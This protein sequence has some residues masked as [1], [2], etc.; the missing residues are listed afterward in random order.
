MSGRRCFHPIVYEA[1]IRT[2]TKIV[3]TKSGKW[4]AIV[5]MGLDES[6]K[7]IQKSVTGSDRRTVKMEVDRLEQVRDNGNAGLVFKH[8]IGAYIASKQ[9]TLSPSTIRGYKSIERVLE[10]SFP[11][12]FNA[13]LSDLD[14]DTLQIMVNDM[15]VDGKSPKRIRNVY[16]LV[17]AVLRYNN[18]LVTGVSL[19]EPGVDKSYQPTS[20]DIKKLIQLSV[21]TELN[22]PIRL[23]TH[24]LRQGEVC[25]L[26]Y[27]NDFR[28]GCIIV[29]KSMVEKSDWTYT[30]KAPKNKTS[31]RRVPILDETLVS[32]IAE[33]GYVTNLLPDNLGYRYAS[34]I[35]RN[36]LPHIRFHDLRHFY[37]SYLHSKGIP[38]AL[39]MK[40]GGWKTDNVMK[41]V[42]RYAMDDEETL[43]KARISYMEDLFM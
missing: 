12:V 1:I 9:H 13:R 43:E 21:G 7:R 8:A 10:T 39:I 32:D 20:D 29:T 4:H 17:S 26:R 18:Y 6:G 33:Q 36:N 16:G 23:G 27:P 14:R 41:K 28:D 40:Y 42:Y 5:Y 25:A 31:N 24:G 3:K 30:V 34:F 2:M 35:K 19:P 37:A 38:D 15:L 11:D 22:I